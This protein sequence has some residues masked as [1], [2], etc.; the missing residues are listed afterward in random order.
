MPRARL[1]RDATRCEHARR[2]LPQKAIRRPTTRYAAASREE[3]SLVSRGA[4]HRA[5]ETAIVRCSEPR[6]PHLLARLTSN[7][8]AGAVY[9]ELAIRSS[10][11]PLAAR[12]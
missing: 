5:G 8:P 4:A 12:C 1:S 10:T 6:R 9:V 2:S 3:R 11:G 7:V